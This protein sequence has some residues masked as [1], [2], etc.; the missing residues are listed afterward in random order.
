MDTPVVLKS[1]ESHH[2]GGIKTQPSSGNQGKTTFETRNGRTY[3]VT[4]HESKNASPKV[5]VKHISSE[6]FTAI[7]DFLSGSEEPATEVAKIKKKWNGQLQ[8]KEIANQTIAA[9]TPA[10]LS[11]KIGAF[12]VELTQLQ[13]NAGHAASSPVSTAYAQELTDLIEAVKVKQGALLESL[14]PTSSPDKKAASEETVSQ[15]F[16][17]LK[18]KFDA[19]KKQLDEKYASYE[20]TL[21][22]VKNGSLK[23]ALEERV[24]CLNEKNREGI[25]ES[26]RNAL[27]N[28]EASEVL[29]PGI[30][31]TNCLSEIEIEKIEK[32]LVTIPAPK[33]ESLENATARVDAHQKRMDSFLKYI[34][35][36]SSIVVIKQM[37]EGQTNATKNLQNQIEAGD[38][39]SRYHELFMSEPNLVQ[40]RYRQQLDKLIAKCNDPTTNLKKNGL[41]AL[42]EE[43]DQVLNAIS[44]QEKLKEQKAALGEHIR[45]ALKQ[46]NEKPKLDKENRHVKT[47]NGLI[48]QCNDLNTIDSREK[49]TTVKKQAE[50]ALHSICCKTIKQVAD[51]ILKFTSGDVRS[52]KHAG[53]GGAQNIAH[54]SRPEFSKKEWAIVGALKTKYQELKD[55]SVKSPVDDQSTELTKLAMPEMEQV[56]RLEKEADTLMK[57]IGLGRHISRFLEEN[58]SLSHESVTRLVRL[59]QI[60]TN[61]LDPS[62]TDQHQLIKEARG[63]MEAIVLGKDIQTMIETIE[64]KDNQKTNKSKGVDV[65][66]S[67]YTGAQQSRIHSL[68]LLRSICFL[69]PADCSDTHYQQ[70][71]LS[72]GALALDEIRTIAEKHNA[73]ITSA[74]LDEENRF[75]LQGRTYETSDDLKI[76]SFSVKTQKLQTSGAN[77]VN[78]LNG[79]KNNVAKLEPV[80]E[81]SGN[82]IHIADDAVK[83]KQTELVARIAD[84]YKEAINERKEQIQKELDGLIGEIAAAQ[85]KHPFIA[86][87]AMAAIGQ[88]IEK[89][90]ED[91][92]TLTSFNATNEQG[93]KSLIGGIYT[94]DHAELIA[95]FNVRLE[96][97]AKGVTG[98]VQNWSKASKSAAEKT[99]DTLSL[100]DAMKQESI[101]LSALIESNVEL[102]GL[103]NSRVLDGLLTPPSFPSDSDKLK[104]QYEVFVKS[105]I[106]EIGTDTVSVEEI[107]KTAELIQ[108]NKKEAELATLLAKQANLV[109]EF[110]GEIATYMAGIVRD[111]PNL[112][113]SQKM[114]IAILN[115]LKEECDNPNAIGEKRLA[116]IQSLAS[117]AKNA[118]LAAEIKKVTET[119]TGFIDGTTAEPGQQ[120]PL[121]DSESEIR[122]ELLGLQSELNGGKLSQEEVAKIRER[123]EHLKER[124]NQSRKINTFL[125]NFGMV[126]SEAPKARL[127]R[128]ADHLLHPSRSAE[129]TEWIVTESNY[130]M[131]AIVAGLAIEDKI[132]NGRASCGEETVLGLWKNYTPE[133]ESHFKSL[134]LLKKMCFTPETV[135][136]SEWGQ[137]YL[138]PRNLNFEE[139]LSIADGYVSHMNDKV[140]P[141]GAV[142]DDRDRSIVKVTSELNELARK[143]VEVGLPI[144]NSPDFLKSYQSEINT[145]AKEISNALLELTSFVEDIEGKHPFLV[146]K[147]MPWIGQAVTQLKAEIELLAEVHALNK[148]GFDS[149]SKG[150]NTLGDSVLKTAF[151]KKLNHFVLEA[152][153]L[154]SDGSANMVEAQ[155]MVEEL[156]KIAGLI[157]NQELGGLLTQPLFPADSDEIQNSYNELFQ[158]FI[159]LIGNATSNADQIRE[160]IKTISELKGAIEKRGG[161]ESTLTLVT[162]YAQQNPESKYCKQTLNSDSSIEDIYNT[163][164]A[165]QALLAADKLL[166]V[167]TNN[168]PRVDQLKFLV[169]QLENFDGDHK[170]LSSLINQ[171]GAHTDIIATG[172]DISARLDKLLGS[173][174]KESLPDM[175]QFD[176]KTQSHF[177]TLILLEQICED[178]ANKVDDLIGKFYSVIKTRIGKLS[179]NELFAQDIKLAADR[180]MRNLESTMPARETRGLMADVMDAVDAAIS[181]FSLFTSAEP[182]AKPVSWSRYSGTFDEFQTESIREMR[183]DMAG[184]KGMA[185]KVEETLVSRGSQLKPLEEKTF[186]L[187]TETQKLKVAAKHLH[188][189]QLS[190]WDRM[191]RQLSDWYADF[192]KWASELYDDFLKFIEPVINYFSDDTVKGLDDG[193]TPTLSTTPGYD[194]QSLKGK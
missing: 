16:E 188:Y 134:E 18:T 163:H 32:L 88:S 155:L 76:S 27:K 77:A 52:A 125:Q 21:N 190:F 178:P 9:S 175:C 39:L 86:G 189:S 31:G 174:R 114:Q 108:T 142:G 162:E 183:E 100:N 40:Q 11:Q 150:I 193:V 156:E 102:A 191:S 48:S 7:A 1:P 105:L 57:S 179:T 139:V 149:L 151:E 62:R 120:F 74:V 93:F 181:S 33:E 20:A 29:Q 66:T 8:K 80:I 147:E 110:S 143:I 68:K 113:E 5:E 99:D 126:L 133:Q 121:S 158:S 184:V 146:E 130:R 177:N 90:Q 103:I 50:A 94:L 6:I 152:A 192:S 95:A 161:L 38:A 63:H 3:A 43:A 182:E 58:K 4:L 167:T 124:T 61:L 159:T 45:Q 59:G 180:S 194:E 13:A 44:D 30:A 148:T 17:T 12:S 129:M 127:A 109:K 164:R 72:K 140:N 65:D 154:V 25:K 22:S 14:S 111:M 41:A 107:K 26:F 87:K 15:N 28:L 115:G 169:Q 67:L 24:A 119:I 85:S 186:E 117:V 145:R 54:S 123:I 79:L 104:I 172:N 144:E 73:K 131:K 141:V 176:T 92:A 170:E 75:A 35:D 56:A 84:S 51:T 34:A 55:L 118:I 49:L 64:K 69:T 185:K 36:G 23:T 165:L 10:T 153:G 166:A 138:N 128:I 173:K 97:F 46:A 160:S 53:I 112:N 122:D 96:N 78:T 168:S 70:M 42:K 137:M 157:D 132:I 135:T 81:N 171:M 116:E 82:F 89:L 2:M 47:L 60:V 37:L 106:A 101:R 98:F 91:I 19:I 187:V 83:T 136:A 71:G